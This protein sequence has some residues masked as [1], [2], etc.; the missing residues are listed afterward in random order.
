MRRAV[1]V[2]ASLLAGAASVLAYA[3]FGAFVVVFASLAV[4][5]WLLDRAAGTRDGALLGFAWGLGAF[6]AGVSWLF[7]ALN[8]YGGM[9]VP[10]AGLAIG[11][12]C[13][14]LALYPALVGAVYAHMARGPAAGRAALFAGLWILAEMLRGWVFTGFPWLAVGYTQTPPSPLA[15]LL[16][17]I[18]VYGVGGIVAFVAAL[19]ACV[20]W[21]APLP[22]AS[23]AIALVAV[24][25]VAM[26]AGTRAWVAPQGEA[27]R[28][29]LVQTDIAQD[30][31]WR[32][33]RVREWLD[34]NIELSDVDGA[35]LVVL[36]ESTLPLLAEQLPGGYL[37]FLESRARKRDADL[38][39]GVFLRDEAGRVFNAAAN[40]GASPSQSYAKRHLV[41][42]GEYS[43]PLF[44]WFYALADIPMSDQT[45]GPPDQAPLAVAGQRIAVNICY[46]D[47]FGRELLYA[48]P[49]ATMMLNVSNLAWYGR[50]LAQPQHLQIARVRA[51]ET[52]RPMLRSTNTGMTAV[53]LPS[54]RVEAVLPQFERG[55]LRAE[56]RGY[57]GLTPYTLWGDRAP[58]LL[59]ALALTFG[60]GVRGFG[61]GAAPSFERRR[62]DA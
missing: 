25:F 21:R 58:L 9:P 4:L 53:V 13:A 22:A 49:Q 52:G 7:V 23:A 59:A 45:P 50:S 37:D 11:L 60:L 36:P 3:P 30:L 15:G 14:Y 47:L 17:V 46:E 44:G 32:P 41:P 57:G 54:G 38:I 62:P 35:D 34:L 5:V 28:V 27:V 6:V 26:H 51:M 1:A 55:V 29:A 19:A 16:P 33:E 10:V 31:K 56:V 43:P 61:A 8:R 2:P 12:F 42:F 39:L 24:F 20:R 40:L 18:G 48:V